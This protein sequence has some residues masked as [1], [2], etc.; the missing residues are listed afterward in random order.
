MIIWV[1]LG[2]IG[3]VFSVISVGIEAGDNIEHIVLLKTTKY[4]ILVDIVL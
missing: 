4:F 3:I 1:I 2:V